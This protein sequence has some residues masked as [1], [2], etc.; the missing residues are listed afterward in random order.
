MNEESIIRHRVAL[1][2]RGADAV[3]AAAKAKASELNVPMCIALVDAGGHL[4]AFSRSDNARLANIQMAITKATS[5][6]VRQRAT[7]EEGEIRPD[8]PLAPIRTALAAGDQQVTA[9]WGGIPITIDGQV[10]AGIGVSGG[11]RHE[12]VPVAEAGIAAL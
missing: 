12:D 11:T 9:M 4:L 8:D 1:S 2:A 6:V 10:V 7:A 5:A 3:M